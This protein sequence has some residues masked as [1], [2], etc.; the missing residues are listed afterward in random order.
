MSDELV[1]LAA[2]VA[3]TKLA[4]EAGTEALI[5][6]MNVVLE[7]GRPAILNWLKERGVRAP[8]DRS[9]IANAMSST[10]RQGLLPDLA[11]PTP[12]PPTAPGVDV[13][14]PP[15]ALPAVEIKA[16]PARGRFVKHATGRPRVSWT[17]ELP[18]LKGKAA[19]RTPYEIIA[20]L[21]TRPRPAGSKPF[22]EE[23]DAAIERIS[24]KGAVGHVYGLHF[25]FTIEMIREFG[26]AWLTKA[27]RAAGTLPEDNA[28]VRIAD[29]KEFVG[30][31]AA[32]KC[33]IT[34]EYAR[35]D[36]G[37]LS[38]ELFCKYPFPTSQLTPA[39]RKAL[40]AMRFFM[41]NDAPEL[42]FMRILSRGAPS[43]GPRYAFGDICLE[44]GTC[45]LITEK[46]EV[47]PHG[48]DVG[49]YELESIPFKSVDYLL[50]EPFAYYEAITSAAA[51][52]AAW[53][54]SEKRVQHIF[55]PPMYPIAYIMST[56][57]KLP[58]FFDFLFEVAPSLTPAALQTDWLRR[59][60]LEVLPDV[61]RHQK[62]ILTYLYAD[63][64]CCGFI[65]PNMNLDNGLFWRDDAGKLEA[66]FID[67]GRFRNSNYMIG[68]VNGYMCCDECE[69]LVGKDSA[70]LEAFARA[71]KLAGG[72]TLDVATLREHYLLA[73]LHLGLTC[74][75]VIDEIYEFG[76]LVGLDKAGWKTVED[77]KDP[78]IFSM[79]NYRVGMVHM[80]RTFVYIWHHHDLPAF[81][82][83]WKSENKLADAA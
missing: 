62:A 48:T 9:K 72:P 39:G 24:A 66:G 35:E 58:S 18:V 54:K 53:G 47:P 80:I 7:G 16:P 6:E 55:P 11:P 5:A 10:R 76:A 38:T 13:K 2:L 36:A 27:L 45:L 22:D 61:E 33:F 21:H 30:G 4:D 65:H 79:P 78:R 70:L 74:I 64:D 26:A 17:P 34:V 28:V 52:L 50:D 15:P 41:N 19:E 8:P 29:L 82:H 56:K 3:K 14:A 12:P 81:W 40:Y 31:S 57:R 49:P 77:Y 75:A 83:N 32:R 68:L 1:T 25:P 42:D 20:G 43:F 59:T 63:P 46:L 60:V 23:Y 51:R 67:W 69:M 37:M 71:H 73:W 44:T